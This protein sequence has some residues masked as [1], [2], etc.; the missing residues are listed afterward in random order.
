MKDYSRGYSRV[1]CRL[2]AIQGFVG[3][4]LLQG[5]WVKDLSRVCKERAISGFVG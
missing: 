4:W 1:K 2:R 3:V 5:L